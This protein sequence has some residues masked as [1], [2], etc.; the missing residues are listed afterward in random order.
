[1]KGGEL[2]L[3]AFATVLILWSFNDYDYLEGSGCG[4]F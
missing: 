2:N 4:V 3:E 1:M